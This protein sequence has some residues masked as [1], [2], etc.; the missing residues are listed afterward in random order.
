MSD[1]F[2]YLFAASIIFFALA[3]ISSLALSSR[4]R[5]CIYL[6]HSLVAIASLLSGAFAVF[7]IFSSDVVRIELPV[8]MLFSDCELAIDALSA[9]FILVISSISLVVSI[10]SI[11]YCADYLE[12]NIGWLGFLHSTFVL[13]MIFVVSAN[14]AFLFL[15]S[16]E[17]MSLVS[18][19]LV[20]FEHERP[21]SKRAGLIYIIM[22]HI[23]TALI[24]VAFLLL[25]KETGSFSFDDF[26]HSGPA[27]ALALRNV[28][29][30]LAF[31]GFGTKAGIVPLHI[32]LPHAHP[33]A[34][35]NVSA[36]MSGVMIKT[37]IYGIVRVSFDFLGATETWWGYAILLVGAVSAV[38]GVLYALMEHDIKRLLAFHSVENI[39]IILMG[40]GAAVFFHSTGSDGLAALALVAGLFH[41]I[42]HAI[43]KGLLFLGAGAVV[44]STKTKNI[45]E[46][47]GLIK[48]MPWTA[49]FFLVGSV[50]I[51]ALPPFNGFVS[52]W[53]VF[54]AL[55]AGFT[56]PIVGANVILPLSG[57]LLALTSALAAA[58]FV[59]AFGITFLALPRSENAK[60]ASEVPASMLA[61]MGILALLC[62]LLGVIPSLGITMLSEVSYQTV[63]EGM[64]AGSL[65]DA[66]GGLVL[67]PSDARFS[68]MST[69]VV[70]FVMLAFLPVV[71]ALVYSLGGRTKVRKSVTWDCGMRAPNSRMEYTAT[72]FTEPIRTLFAGLFLPNKEVH[73]ED[74]PYYK[75]NMHFE[76][77]VR[78]IFEE[79]AYLPFA[80]AIM[81]G[82]AR[83]RGMQSGSIQRY[84]GYIFATLLILLLATRWF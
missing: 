14:D 31:V 11:G 57:A 71:M 60:N 52:E 27:S 37:A 33:A 36:L 56:L 55:L 68:S 81:R 5:A 69:S 13:S 45:E 18:Y 25:Y 61:G 30:V 73:V 76:V 21:G 47:G 63:G 58:C 35:S 41:T 10:Y 34:P 83:V 29:F 66:S 40:V 38:L 20:V 19:F 79:Y 65:F 46:L 82:A 6:T 32:W 50:A 43:F 4:K 26:K 15:V 72:A 70:A 2:S 7:A 22:T 78:Q 67:V 23:G 74:A 48:K 84:L 54:Q 59:K 75:K 9:L 39:G 64:P 53:L 51:S 62:L 44:H 49:L 24:T 3:S 77:H 42:N 1:G 8:A 16:W 80:G 28:A 17:V 12:H